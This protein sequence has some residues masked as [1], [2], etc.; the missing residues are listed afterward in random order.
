MSRITTVVAS[1]VALALTTTCASPTAPD[2]LPTRA[3][4]S[5]E[6]TAV[7][8]GVA[9]DAPDD[10]GAPR[11]VRAVVPRVAI[12][13]MTPDEAARDH[14]AAL[15]PLWIAPHRR[16]ADLA[17]IGEQR[18][19]SGASIVRLQQR[20]DGVDIHQGELRVMVQSDGSL[21][22]I[23][24][25]MHAS[26]GRASFR[27]SATAALEL[28]LD[29]L[30]GDAR[31][32]PVIT[33][34]ADTAGYRALTVADNPEFRVQRAR[35][36]PE[37]LPAGDQLLAIWSVELVAEKLDLDDVTELV[38]RRYLIGDADGRLVRD[39]DLVA[40]DAFTYR[41]FADPGGRPL[42]GALD[43]FAPHPTGMP[44]G[45]LPPPAPYDLVTMEAFNGPR[46]PW[47]PAG[48]T[49]T[50]GNNVDAFADIFLPLG[51][52]DGDIRP[53]VGPDRTFDRRY[54][55]TAEPL[56][57]EDQSMAAAVNVF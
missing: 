34:S 51:F 29:A 11:L 24:G 18:L 26:A 38:A 47:L 17:S 44:D 22:A 39:V 13:G 12:A 3:Q 4:S 9:I 52:N 30:Y 8:L 21:A 33:E 7:A 31:T 6:L 41:V 5:A 10:S 16:A 28:A 48:A 36:R 49:T 46:D 32:R 55:F 23:S 54:D 37:L 27:S 50:T 45:S 15:A 14:L 56:A 40:S 35:A 2:E 43:S 19:R 25:T 1:G 57:S 20:I 42:D 53:Q